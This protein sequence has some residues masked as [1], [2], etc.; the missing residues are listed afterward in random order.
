MSVVFSEN[1][2]LEEL[3]NLS[4]NKPPGPDDVN[5]RILVELVKSVAPSL[6]VLFQ[7][8]Y[9][10]GIVPSDWKRPNI[11][12]IYKKND[13]KDP[14]NYFLVSL[15][16]ILYK[17]ME[18]VI[19]EHLLKYLEDNNILSNKQ[20]GFLP[21]RSTVLQLLN[22]LDQWTEAIDNGF[23]VDVIYCDFMKA[24]DKVPH[25]RLLKVLKYCCIPSKIVD[26][27]ETFLTNRKQRVIV[28]GTP[29]S[30]HDM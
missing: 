8:S 7:N 16:T 14:E 13:K 11:T 20:Y 28:N 1:I 3:Q 19:K 21:G 24:F 6:S 29:S 5:S 18:S 9:D 17:I 10:T 2:V 15:T 22:V 23:Y 27:V 4:I 25:K 30:W 12:P 26:W